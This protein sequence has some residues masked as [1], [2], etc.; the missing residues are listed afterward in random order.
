MQQDVTVDFEVKGEVYG[1]TPHDVFGSIPLRNLGPVVPWL[2]L[3]TVAGTLSAGE[4][5]SLILTVNTTGMADGN[6]QAWIIV[7]DNFSHET[8][9]P[10]SLMIDTY[11]SDQ[12]PE[13]PGNRVKIEIMPNPFRDKTLIKAKI[14]DPSDISLRI[15][16]SQGLMVRSEIIH[17][18]GK[19]STLEYNWDGRNNEGSLL[20]TGVY[21]LR[22]DT[23]NFSGFARL[24]ILR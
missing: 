3:D 22:I 17:Q 14:E 16:N 21:M 5:D 6:Y 15:F 9:I 8:V 19:L 23:G 20:P 2:S 12:E 18:E 24:I 1:G 10:V 7:N 4:T 11:L 13:N